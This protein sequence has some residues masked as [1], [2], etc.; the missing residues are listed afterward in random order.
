MD[1]LREDPPPRVRPDRSAVA[2][3]NEGF[4]MFESLMHAVWEEFARLIF[5]VEVEVA[6]QAQ[7][8]FAP[9]ESPARMEYSG[10]TAEQPS[11]LGQAAVATAAGA[12]PPPP[13]APSRATP[14]RQRRAR[15][16]GD[17]RQGGARQDRPQRPLL[18]RLGQEVQE[19]PRRV[20]PA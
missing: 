14:G 12:T 15:R 19:V 1:Y 7:E 11:A 2:Y 10:G 16:A 13:S 6:P 5:H 9:G 18:V 8:Q 3:K 17:R 20:T 4:S